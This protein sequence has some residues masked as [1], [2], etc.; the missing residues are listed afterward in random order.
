MQTALD[1]LMIHR[2]NVVI[3]FICI[4]TVLSFSQV[5]LAVNPILDKKVYAPGDTVTV[6]LECVIPEGH[7]LYGNPLGPGIGKPFELTLNDGNGVVWEKALKTP[8]KK[9]QPPI[10]G[11]V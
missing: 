4:L 2:W 7:H 9:Y 3:F 10:D 11:W 5:D 8:P 6:A 1:L